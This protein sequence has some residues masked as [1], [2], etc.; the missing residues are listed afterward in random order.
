MFVPIFSHMN[1]SLPEIIE[2]YNIHFRFIPSLMNEKHLFLSFGLYEVHR[3]L[4]C[5]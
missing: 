3:E 5:K 4:E 1:D 2:I